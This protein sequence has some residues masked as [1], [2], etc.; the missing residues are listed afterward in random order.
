MP[1]QHDAL[2]GDPPVDVPPPP[3]RELTTEVWKQGQDH[4]AR[5]KSKTCRARIVWAFVV[6]TGSRLPFEY[7]LEVVSEH[8]AEDGRVIQVVKLRSHF[9]TCPD[10]ARFRRAKGPAHA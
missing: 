5:C 6:K 3:R 8:E 2:I 9:A 10:A 7:P 4:A 1:E